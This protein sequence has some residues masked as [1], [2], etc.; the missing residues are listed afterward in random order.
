MLTLVAI[1]SISLTVNLPGLAITPILDKLQTVFGHVTQLEIQLLTVLPNFVTIPFILCSGKICTPRNQITVLGIGLGLYALTGVLY[2]FATSMTELIILSCILGVGC[3]LVIPLAASL[4]SQYFTGASRTRSLG[5][6]SGLSNAAVIAA[7]LFVGW[8][9]S[10]SWHLAFVVYLVPLIPLALIPF[11]SNRFIANHIR[12][13]PQSSVA[14]AAPV[15]SIAVNTRHRRL[16]LVTIMAIYCLATFGV[17]VVAYYLPFT[18]NHYHMTDSRVGVA[19]AMFYAAATLSGFALTPFVKVLRGATV[20]IAIALCAAGLLATGLMHGYYTYLGAILI[21]GV[22]Y[23]ILQPVIYDK[24]SQL[25]PTPQ[26]STAYFAYLLTCNYVGISLVPFVIS[27]AR[28]LFHASAD[29]NF[30]YLFNAALMGLLLI[31][32]L[33][34]RKKFAF[35]ST[36]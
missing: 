18:M 26:R 30:S 24:T 21:M 29:V 6:K 9:A 8:M 20:P 11:M 36:L 23:G 13:D 2:F 28:D 5:M 16:T 12:K 17:E 34:W 3:G 10:I 25:A 7:T 19:T 14:A 15:A 32:S 31:V 33:I 4:I 22:G 27:G 35:D 1:L